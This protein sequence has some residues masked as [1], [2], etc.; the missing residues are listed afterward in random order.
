[1]AFRIL[2]R[3]TN[4]DS[5]YGLIG[6]LL[7]ESARQYAGRYVLA[8]GLLAVAA[9]ATAVI[10]WMMRD[11]VNEVFI[12]RNA[13]M[14]WFIAGSF[15]AASIVRGAAN[16]GATIS[17]SRVGNH[18]IADAQ[19]RLFDHILSLGIPFHDRT[20]S[21]ELITRM[22]V[23]ADAARSIL[24]TL[25]TGAGRDFL[26]VVALVCVILIQSPLLTLLF[27]VIGP[28]AVFIVSRLVK[29]VRKAAREE[30]QSL[31]LVVA[32]MQETATGIRVVKAFNLEGAMQ[33][34]M[35]NAIRAVRERANRIARVS[36]AFSPLMDTLAGLAIAG[37]IL[38]G[39]YAVV[40][41]NQQPGAL[42]SLLAAVLLAYEPAR[43][44][45][46]TRVRIE[47]N[48]VGLRLMYELLDTKPTVDTNPDGP[49]LHAPRG[50]VTFEKVDFS[51]RPESPL[52]RGLNFR[53]E[54]GRMT[55]LV[56]PSGGGKSTIIALI[57]RFYDVAGGRILID[58]SDISKVKIDSLHRAISLVTQDTF[59]FN[60]TIREN[61]RFGRPEATDAEVEAAARDALA[62]DF[63][64]ARPE[65]YDT[66][67]GG[68]ATQL[69][70]GQR[71]R[72]AIAR[73]M[74]RNAPILLLDEAT[75][76]LDTE[77][78]RQVQI[79]FARLM[80]GRTTIVIAH[81][82]S[83]ILGAHHICVLVD[84]RIVE[85]GRHGE[86]LAA[87]GR[88]ARLYRLQFERQ[89]GE[90]RSETAPAA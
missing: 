3:P 87:G 63:I 56:G 44:L 39:G 85:E 26:T 72:I 49:D 86:L 13:V 74:L 67:I 24:E 51:Y 8:F 43:R 83:T 40:Y 62:H 15:F 79:A 22:T 46:G 9:S 5:A 2:P 73:A 32:G 61:I 64:V 28:I 88:Y 27:L 25:V 29:R 21:S 35:H 33:Q 52:F 47:A 10:A 66:R 12:G 36:A 75:S 11:V 54:P 23:N 42:L 60:D 77:S 7:S 14:L 81:R 16:Y 82:L 37:I 45:G 71:Q 4:P 80:A 34:R 30:Y 65:G 38:V 84:G 17:L 59:L 1:M 55:A 78:E 18:I 20:H 69:S 48:L 68:E 31:G 57:E 76:A 90:A 19:R 50:G 58:G 70:G 41:L 89:E 6:R 53:A